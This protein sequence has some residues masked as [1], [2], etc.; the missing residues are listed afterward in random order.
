MCEWACEWACE[1]ECECECEW[2]GVGV[3]V[4][5]IWVVSMLVMSK[6]VEG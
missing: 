6:V 4:V 2:S 3:G 1:C 5:S